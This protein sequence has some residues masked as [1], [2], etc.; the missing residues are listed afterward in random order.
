MDKARK[1]FLQ[2]SIIVGVA[3]FPLLAFA[4]ASLPATPERQKE[5]KLLLQEILCLWGLEIRTEG[6]RSSLIGQYCDS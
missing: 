3:M 2:F 1:H 4:Q 5:E 6:H